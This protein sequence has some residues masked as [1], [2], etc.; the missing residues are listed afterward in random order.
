MVKALLCDLDGTLLDIDFNGFM[1]EYLTDVSRRFA[2][3]IPPER[4]QRQGRTPLSAR[5]PTHR[6][7]CTHPP[8]PMPAP[9]LPWTCD[10]A[11]TC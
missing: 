8:A 2:D 7:H 6:H 4:F 3:C 5:A 1:R 11:E 9:A 10:R